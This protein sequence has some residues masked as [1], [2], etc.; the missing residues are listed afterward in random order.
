MSSFSKKRIDVIMR[1]SN[2][3]TFN[4]KG[5]NTITL[6]GLRVEAQISNAGAI[7]ASSASI[8]IYGMTQSDM[9]KLSVIAIGNNQ[10][11][12]TAQNYIELYAGDDKKMSKVFEGNIFQ[13]WA[14]YSG[15]PEVPLV[16]Q[17]KPLVVAQTTPAESMPGKGMPMLPIV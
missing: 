6:K 12:Y 11:V 14:D 5:N 13:A 7:G 9:N 2:N 8:K 4:D 17:A 10:N 16:I 3:R 15:L 1:L